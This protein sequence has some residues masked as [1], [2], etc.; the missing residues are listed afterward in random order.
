VTPSA[1]TASAMAVTAV[2]TAAQPRARSATRRAAA[3][4]RPGVSSVAEVSD[5]RRGG[6]AWG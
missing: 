3:G 1:P 4:A 6:C 5:R 2:A